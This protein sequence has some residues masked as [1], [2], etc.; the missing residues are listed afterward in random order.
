LADSWQHGKDLYGVYHDLLGFLPDNP[1]ESV[2]FRV[3]NNVI[4]SQVASMVVGS[5]Y[6]SEAYPLQIQPSSIDSLEPA[7]TCAAAT[8]LSGNYSVGS[9]IAAWTHHLN[10]SQSLFAALDAIS[11]VPTDDEGFHRSWDHYYDNLSARQCHDKPLPCNMSNSNLCV[12]QEQADSVFR[13]GQHEYSYIYR[14]APE[15]LEFATA[16]YGIWVAELAQSIRRVISGE[17]RMR[18]RHNIAHDGSMSRLLSILQVDVMVW[19]GMGAE[20]VFEL[21]S[22]EHDDGKHFL[23]VLWGGQVLKSSNPSLGEMNMID[24]DVFLGYIDGLV[25]RQAVKI[26][27]LCRID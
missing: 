14:N 20:I 25:G 1:D 18:Y 16:S 26:Q 12:S 7:Y 5:M 13:L 4:T 9:D 22:K 3:T 19:P 23:R 6:P 21:Y 10:A 2:S 8:S 15:S 17:T 11:N 27:D 24:V